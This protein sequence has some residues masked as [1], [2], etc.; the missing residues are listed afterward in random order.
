GVL[1]SFTEGEAQEGDS[2]GTGFKKQ[3]AL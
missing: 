2:L 3:R 1:R